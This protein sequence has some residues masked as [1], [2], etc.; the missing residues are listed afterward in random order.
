MVLSHPHPDHFLGLLKVARDYSVGEF[1]DTGQGEAHGAGP[2]YAELLSVLRGKQVPI[3]RPHELCGM[4]RIGGATVDVL[5][6]CPG[7]DPALSA[8]DNSFVLRIAHGQRAALLVGDAEHEAEQR[9][10]TTAAGGLH[11][12][13]LK[14]GH[15]GSRSSTT[16]AFLDAVSPT[17]ASISCGVRN[18]FGHPHPETLTTLTAAGVHMLRLDRLGSIIWQTDGHDQQISAFS[19]GH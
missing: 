3:K 2:V 17:F 11:A 19:E 13:L 12:D 9:L 18:R 14:V 6:P 16:P 5:S 15:H 4:H 10:L 8:N 7:Y 1:W